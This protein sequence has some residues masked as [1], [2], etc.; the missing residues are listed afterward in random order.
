MEEMPEHLFEDQVLQC[1]KS[2][3]PGDCSPVCQSPQSPK[4]PPYMSWEDDD[5][6]DLMVIESPK[7]M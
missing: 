5:F 6:S 3:L 2:E 7:P 4:A 1:R